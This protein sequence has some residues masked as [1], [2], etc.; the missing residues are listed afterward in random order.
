M[1][2][3][4]KTKKSSKAE[5][6]A[7]AAPE[8]LTTYKGFTKDLVCRGHQFEIGKTYTVRGRV[9][10]C[11]NG[12]HACSNPWD[13]LSYYP[14]LDDECNFNRFAETLQSGAIDKHSQ[15]S[16]IASAE[17]TIKA[18]FT[19]PQFVGK[20]VDWIVDA[21]KPGDSAQIGSSGHSARIGSSG[22]YA[23]IGSSGHSARIGSSD[24]SAQIGSSGDSAQIGSSG[25]YAQIGSSGDSARI[26]SSGHSAQIGSS[27]HSAQIGSSGDYAQIGSSGD[28][29]RIGSSGHSARI[30]SSG[31]YAQIGSS[32]DSARIG[33]SDHSAQIGSS[34]DSAR[35]GS[36][37]HYAQIKAEGKDAVIASAGHVMRVHAPDGTWVSLAE[38]DSRGKCIGFA[39][40]CVGKDG[41]P[42]NTWLIA[43]GGKLI[44]EDA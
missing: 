18:E 26:G 37:G 10:A 40:G 17:I 16:K 22:D 31:H 41:I 29:A 34:G 5:Q 15:D 39:T 1:A 21:T 35:I 25:D 36:S 6:S 4:A 23:Q 38:Y 30:G 27:G 33:S 11:S 2:A 3:A 42:A 12:F 24:H 13:V 14:L 7:V 9:S 44:A 43:K 28:Y 32:G 19:I 8:V 20:L